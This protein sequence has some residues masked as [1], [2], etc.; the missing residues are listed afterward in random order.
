MN[1]FVLV[2]V[3]V[4]VAVGTLIAVRLSTGVDTESERPLPVLVMV[5]A[6]A[7]IVALILE[8]I[9]RSVSASPSQPSAIHPSTGAVSPTAAPTGPS[10]GATALQYRTVGTDVRLRAGATTNSA[11]ITVMVDRGSLL[12]LSCYQSGQSVLG[13]TYWYRAN[14]GALAGYVA[15]YWVDTGP[16]PAYTRLTRC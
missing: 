7:V 14:Y 16:D 9:A 6:L 1:A 3:V 13:D 15:G 10:Y 4:A 2:L 8:A 5:F 12:I 11:I